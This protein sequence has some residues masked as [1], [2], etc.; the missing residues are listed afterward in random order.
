MPVENVEYQGPEVDVV[1]G[2]KSHNLRTGNRVGVRGFSR[3]TIAPL[4]TAKDPIEPRQFTR[5]ARPAVS[6]GNS[7]EN[8]LPLLH[9]GDYRAE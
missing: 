3:E 6:T 1:Y 9:T 2:A 4:P 7:P 5:E 8:G